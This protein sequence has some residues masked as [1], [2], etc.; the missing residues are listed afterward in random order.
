MTDILALDVATK[1]GWARGR[2]RDVPTSG[3]I[4]F[5]AKGASH[6]AIFAGAFDW[7]REFTE[8]ER[9]DVLVLEDLLPFRAKMGQTTKDT[10]RVLAGL[11][12][13]IRLVAFKRGMFKVQAVPVPDVRHHF[14]GGNYKREKAEGYTIEKCRSLGWR[15]DRDP[16]AA[17]ALALWSYWAA[18]VVPET[19]L[20][21]SPL[22]QKGI[23]L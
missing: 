2:P 22:F 11:H 15:C 23:A 7:F 18:R 12:G 17:N 14:I 21:V 13:V 20:R 3:S 19:A 9:P 5:A 6:G 8:N 10:A 1:T 4:R 16:D